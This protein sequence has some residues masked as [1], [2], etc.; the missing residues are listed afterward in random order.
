MLGNGLR[1]ARSP[2]RSLDAGL[3]M[4]PE[5]RVDDG[6]ILGRSSIENT[7]LSRL[8]ALSTLGVVRRTAERRGARAMLERCGVR[9]ARYSAAVRLLSGGNQQKVLFAR[10]LFCGPHVLIADEPTR[11][12]DV[13]AKRAIYDLVVELADDGLGVLVISS[14][15]D[16]IL[17]LAHRVLVMRRGRIVAELSGDELTEARILAAV[18][19]DD[20]VARTSA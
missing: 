1:G 20:T 8:E 4:I 9:G 15:L 19:E 7:A 11:G 18:F 12:V 5:S 10:T 6:L 3:A 2:R 13:G 17:G 14:E 16:E